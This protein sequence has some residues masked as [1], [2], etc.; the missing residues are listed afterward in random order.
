MGAPHQVF[1]FNN[2]LDL[3]IGASKQYYFHHRDHQPG[4][5]MHPIPLCPSDPI[6]P[7]WQPHCFHWKLFQQKGRVQFDQDRCHVHLSF[8]LH[9]G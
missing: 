7:C 9:Q 5:F 2:V 3:L 1:K 6:Q 8:P 4:I